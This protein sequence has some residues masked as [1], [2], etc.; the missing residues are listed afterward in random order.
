MTALGH[1]VLRNDASAVA[2]LLDHGA[3][4]NIIGTS[5]QLA[6]LPA[7]PIGT[8]LLILT[9]W[10]KQFFADFLQ[11]KPIIPPKV[12]PPGILITA[13]DKML[14]PLTDP[15]LKRDIRRNIDHLLSI[16]PET[17]YADLKQEALLFA[18]DNKCD[19]AIIQTLIAKGALDT[20]TT[21]K[22][23]A[24]MAATSRRD[25][26]SVVDF[27]LEQGENPNIADRMGIRL[28]FWRLKQVIGR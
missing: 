22:Q 16:L 13:L 8:T 7:G 20:G 18:L 3:N 1:A 14:G 5:G 2:M 6:S 25:N 12:F 17:G 4:P 9:N 21:K 11:G 28:Y 10:L 19:Q 23:T 24:L 26:V 27:L 15:V